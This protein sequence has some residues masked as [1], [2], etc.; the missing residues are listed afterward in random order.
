MEISGIEQAL[1]PIIICSKTRLCENT[2]Q[3]ENVR[4]AVS[5]TKGR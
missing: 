5:D 4:P 3:V 2:E 1:L